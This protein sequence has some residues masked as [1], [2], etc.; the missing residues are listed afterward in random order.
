MRF[1]ESLAL[2]LI[3]ASTASV[4][5]TTLGPNWVRQEGQRESVKSVFS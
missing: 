3:A 2:V 4:E 5:A 1:L